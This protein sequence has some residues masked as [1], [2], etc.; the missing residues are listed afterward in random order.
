MGTG[1]KFN[2]KPKTR[3]K[4]NA[5][6][7]RRRIALHRKRLIALGMDEKIVSK[8]DT[9]QMRALLKCPEKTALEA[10]KSA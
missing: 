2:K 7:R 5:T 10:A 1:R 4:K 3:P 9:K 8:L 6:D